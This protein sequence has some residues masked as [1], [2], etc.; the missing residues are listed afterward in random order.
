VLGVGWGLFM[1]ISMSRFKFVF[2][3]RLL[4]VEDI[5]CAM[6]LFVLHE[7]YDPEN[8]LCMFVCLGMKLPW[9]EVK[10]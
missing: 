2:M 4:M 1:S 10:A 9:L 8:L 7:R 6:L 5:V 3:L